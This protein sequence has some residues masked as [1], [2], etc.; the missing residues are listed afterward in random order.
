M[1]ARVLFAAAAL[2]ASG[3]VRHYIPGTE[4]EENEDT[5]AIVKLM[6]KYRLA[7]EGRDTEALMALVSPQFRD[8]QGTSTPEDDIDFRSL[9]VEL[10]NRFEHIDNVH[11]SIDVRSIEVKKDD[12]SAVYYWTLQWRMPGLAEKT[13]SSSEL[14]RMQFKRTDRVWKIASGI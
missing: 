4:I 10:K 2:L 8:N 1:S 13:Q 12:A 7:V 6:E 14:K 3:C 11:L 9:P 5:S